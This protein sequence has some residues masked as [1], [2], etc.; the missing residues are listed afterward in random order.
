MSYVDD[1]GQLIA[2]PTSHKRE[3]IAHNVRSQ[4]HL[5][6][7]P[8]TRGFV[9]LF[10][11]RDWASRRVLAW[12]LANKLTTDFCI[13]AVQEAPASY[14]TPDIFNTDQGC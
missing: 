4:D 13:E 6:F 2:K 7:I 3:S 14:D 10:A 9:F 8:M 11:G 1:T 12:R 5:S